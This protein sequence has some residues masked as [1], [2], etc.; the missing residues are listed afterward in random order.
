MY[1]VLVDHI[2]DGAFLLQDNNLLL[3]NEVGASMLGYTAAE[4]I[5][6]PIPNI[7]APEHRQ[8]VM[9]MKRNPFEGKFSQES[10]VFRLLHKDGTTRVS[11]IM[12]VGMSTSRNRPAFV[13][14]V[15]RIVTE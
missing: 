3:C 4:I 11:V 6:L 14:T 7:I 1:R 8:M 5:G 2:R 15:R 13:G 12:S 10:Y 9:E